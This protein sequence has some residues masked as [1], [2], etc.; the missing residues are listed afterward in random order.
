MAVTSN[1]HKAIDN[2]L[3]AVADR[4]REKCVKLKAVKK[5]SGDD[6]GPNDE[7]IEVTKSNDDPKL[8]EYPLVGGTAWLF[9]R[10][11]L[12]QTFDYLFVDEA[13]QVS[14][15]NAVAM[16]TCARNLVLVGDPMQLAQP[17]QGVHPG[18]SGLS[19]L[20]YI[21]A[22]HATA[23]ADRGMFLPVSRRMHPAVCRYISDIVYEGRLRSDPDT[24]RQQINRQRSSEKALPSAGIGFIEV[25]ARGQQSVFTRRG[26]GAGSD[27]QD[28]AWVV[29][30]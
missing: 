30:P 23:P 5:V 14:L 16:A 21:L 17:I 15:A 2:L 10:E 1:S 12:D 7:L 11:E 6:A 13:G 8:T 3:R 27:L 26:R 24:E 28:S 18:E 4:A 25:R 19:A 22:G 29:V 20:E 9:S